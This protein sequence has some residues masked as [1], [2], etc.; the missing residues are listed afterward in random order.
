MSQIPPIKTKFPNFKRIPR[1]PVPNTSPT[2]TA[3]LA[4]SS[5]TGHVE[6]VW[7]NAEMASVSEQSPASAAWGSMDAP[8][9]LSQG[10]NFPK[11]TPEQSEQWRKEA[12]ESLKESKKRRRAEYEAYQRRLGV[13]SKQER[14]RLKGTELTT[15][16][17]SINP[18]EGRKWADFAETDESDN[19]TPC[20]RATGVKARKEKEGVV[21]YDWDLVQRI[22][23]QSI[24]L[25]R[26]DGKEL[27][28]RLIRRRGP[29]EKTYRMGP[30]DTSSDSEDSSQENL[31]YKAKYLGDDC[32]EGFA[33]PNPIHFITSDPN[34]RRNLKPS[35]HVWRGRRPQKLQPSS[36]FMACLPMLSRRLRT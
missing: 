3:A 7:P 22:K 34:Q 20:I 11:I 35:T 4:S 8:W 15:N 9:D 6:I 24:E 26:G 1:I 2:E 17:S 31:A 36:A 12:Q 25:T 10:L 13:P 33:L 30:V 29:I 14:K 16:V 21:F 32:H 19:G 5:R 28:P 18:P 23:L 27:P